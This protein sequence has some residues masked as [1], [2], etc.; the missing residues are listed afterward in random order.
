ME[1]GT[2]FNTH[3]TN[4][5]V[6]DFVTMSKR[7]YDCGFQTMW[8]ND[9]A[10]Y[11]NVFIVLSAVAAKVPIKLGTATIVPYFHQP[12]DLAAKLAT[13]SELCEGREL[14]IGIAVGD[15][16]Q[17]QAFVEFTRR[18]SMLRETAVFLK[19]T[20][21]GETVGFKDFPNLT[22]TFHLNPTGRFK[23]AFPPAGPLNLYGGSLGPKSLALAGEYMDGVVFPGQ[24]L[25]CL[26]T[27][28]L[29][30]MLE[31]AHE[32]AAREGT[33]KTLRI[34]ALV[35]VSILRN[36]VKARQF[37]L[38]QVAHSI[39]SLKVLNFSSEEFEQLGID[40]D[41]VDR[42]EKMFAAGATIEEAAHLVDDKMISAYYLAGTPEDVAPA[43]I[44][45]AKELQAYGINE[46]VFS[47]MGPDYAE[48]LDLLASEVLPYLQN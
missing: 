45:L 18:L 2:Q 39:V 14:S 48:S 47:K 20:L 29:K 36:R 8:L 17:T 42:L 4:Y 6:S 43:A 28:R 10:R 11:R 19:R 15:L 44:S 31:Q 1:F 34:A 3:I 5:S 26:R 38:P 24:F 41:R 33:S 21:G 7:A 16:G 46:L 27:G 30:R 13:L 9:N 40:P 37:A 25:A 23:L 32:A 35:N 12:L 22:K